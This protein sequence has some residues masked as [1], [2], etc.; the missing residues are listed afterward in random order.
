MRWVCEGDAVLECVLGSGVVVA[1]DGAVVWL[2]GVCSVVVVA[3]ACARVGVC[4]RVGA[5]GRVGARVRA[6]GRAAKEREREKYCY[7]D[8]LSITPAVM[9]QVLHTREHD[10][11]SRY[12]PPGGG[13]GCS[14]P[15]RGPKQGTCATP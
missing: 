1:C 3:R 9:L 4:G 10:L 6:G 12:G 2:C 14:T 11:V 13:G 15:S 5:S 8:F 7:C